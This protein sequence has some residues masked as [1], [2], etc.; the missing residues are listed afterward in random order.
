MSYDPRI[1]R[2]IS[3]DPVT[4]EGWDPDLYRYVGNSPTNA[5]DP[6]GLTE[7]PPPGGYTDTFIPP[8]RPG[9]PFPPPGASPTTVP[10]VPGGAVADWWN[11]FAP[12]KP[13]M[14]ANHPFDPAHAPRP[15]PPEV[16]PPT[17]PG[18]NVDGGTCQLFPSTLLPDQFVGTG[19][20]GPSVGLL[21]SS[22]GCGAA[23]FHFGTF[24]SSVAP[25][26]NQYTWPPGSHAMICGGNSDRPSNVLM[27]NIIGT[28]S[29]NGI[30]LDGILNAANGYLGSDGRWYYDS[31]PPAFTPM[32]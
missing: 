31:R 13:A 26:I 7:L 9:V 4:F 12:S 30:T 22:P 14:L 6:T 21:I 5:T 19:G 32:P 1:G 17:G 8:P 24:N 23:V 20:C 10:N 11:P 27:Y 2:W 28:L 15:I 3:E 18:T 25:T 16:G 29:Q